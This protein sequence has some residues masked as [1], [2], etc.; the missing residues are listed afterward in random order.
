M[1]SALIAMALLAAEP[2]EPR[3]PAPPP[4]KAQPHPDS[5]VC[6]REKLVGTTLRQ[7]VCM[8]AWQWEERRADDSELLSKAQRNQPGIK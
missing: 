4:K 5:I 2:T 6:K 7:R 8:P 3:T 1:L